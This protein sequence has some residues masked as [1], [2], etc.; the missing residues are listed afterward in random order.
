MCEPSAGDRHRPMATSNTPG[1]TP[2][3][4]VP[5]LSVVVPAFDEAPNLAQLVAQVRDAL[6]AA[7]ITWE[8]IVVDDGSTDDTPATQIG[9]AHV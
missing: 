4:P 2:Q 6:D 5:R 3:N 9:R 7:D 8:L 1:D